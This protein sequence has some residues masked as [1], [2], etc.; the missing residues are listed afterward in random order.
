MFTRAGQIQSHAEA[1]NNTFK[2][3]HTE[4]GDVLVYK[5]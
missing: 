5:D 1:G 2:S 3:M 4:A